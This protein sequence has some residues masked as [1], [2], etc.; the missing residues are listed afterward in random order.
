MVCLDT[1][2]SLSLDVSDIKT[3]ANNK[4]DDQT[5]RL[6]RVI[7]LAYLNKAV[8]TLECQYSFLRFVS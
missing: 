4:D 3:K 7:E 1:K 6:Y 2:S 5:V 8:L